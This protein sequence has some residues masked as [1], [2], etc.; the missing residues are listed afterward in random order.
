MYKK[1]ATLFLLIAIG[2]FIAFISTATILSVVED[3]YLVFGILSGRY[4]DERYKNGIQCF[5]EPNQSFAK[6][7]FLKD[8]PRKY[9]TYIFGSSRVGK[10]PNEL[11]ADQKIY[12]LTYSEGLPAEHLKNITFL[13]KNKVQIKTLL[14]GLDEFSYQIDPQKHLSQLL[15][16]PH[17]AVTGQNYPAFLLRIFA[18]MSII[19]EKRTSRM[20]SF[21]QGDPF[22]RRHW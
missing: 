11:L 5:N 7:V 8:H 6:M 9:D 21:R 19:S 15:R 18:G 13:L 20:I 14:I 12:N 17:P 3:R 10:I 22:L 2:I 1:Y 16:V 4:Y